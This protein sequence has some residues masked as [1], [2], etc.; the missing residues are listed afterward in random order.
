MHLKILKQLRFQGFKLTNV[1]TYV[2]SAASQIFSYD[3]VFESYD[4]HMTQVL[5]RSFSFL[6]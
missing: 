4:R 2:C 5:R 6:K 3:R 1:L